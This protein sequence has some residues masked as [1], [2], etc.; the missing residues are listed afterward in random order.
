MKPSDF[1][2]VLEN[3][4]LES[5]S[6][7]PGDTLGVIY[8]FRNMGTAYADKDY[9]VFV[10]FERT[11]SCEKIPFQ[12]DHEPVISAKS[13]ASGKLIVDGPHQ[14]A[15]P[16]DAEE[17]EYFIHVGLFIPGGGGPHGERVYETYWSGKLTVSQDAPPPSPQPPLP[18]QEI[19][20]RIKRLR[21]RLIDSVSLENEFIRFNISREDG[22][23]EIL[24]KNSG[25]IWASSVT[26]GAFA[27]ITLVKGE[28]QRI[29]SV[30]RFKIFTTEPGSL[31]MLY[32]PPPE[33][34]DLTGL[35]V[36]F[37]ATLVA[38]APAIEFTW[39][40]MP[41]GDWKVQLVRF[42]DEALWVTDA[43]EGAFY[44]PSWLGVA[45]PANSGRMFSRRYPTYAWGGCQ[46]AMVGMSKKGAGL[47]VSWSDPYVTATVQ[48]TIQDLSILPGRQML[49]LTLEHGSASKNVR[50]DVV[51]GG[52]YVEICHAYRPIARAHGFLKL[53]PEKIRENPSAQKLIGAPIFKP[54]TLS[55]TIPGSRFYHGKGEEHVSIGYTFEET[56][57]IAEHLRY[58][59]GIERGLFV[60]AGWIHRGYDNQHPDILPA[61][62]ECGG[63]AALRKASER[64]RATGYLFG[65]HD[66]YLDFYRDAPSW[67]EKY[68][69]VNKDGSLRKGGNWA[70]GQAWFICP[71]MALELAKR[72][73]KNMP[74]VKELFAPTAYFT[75]TT[76]AVGMTECFSPTHPLDYHG[77]I[78]CRQALADYARSLFGVHGSE[79]GMEWAVP[80][81]HYFEGILSRRALGERM[82]PGAY[83]VPLFEL[84]YR[85]CIALYTHQGDKAGPD[86][87]DYILYHIGLGRMPLYAFG[88]HLYFKEEDKK[89][90]VRMLVLPGVEKVMPKTARQF[91]IT[92]RWSV[93][94]P[95]FVDVKR[96]FVHFTD[97]DGNIKFQDDHELPVS[98]GKW[99]KG[100]VILV[101]PRTVNVPEKLTGIFDIRVGLLSNSE[102][103]TLAGQ[104]DRERRYKVGVL[105]L[106][107]RGI[108]FRP[109]VQEPRLLDT[110]CFARCDGGWSEAQTP[111]LCRTDVFI[112]NTYEVLS[113]LNELTAMLP[114]TS[115]R[116]LTPDRLVEETVFGNNEVRVVI[117]GSAHD[118]VIDG[119][120]LPPYGFIVKSPTF[121]AFHAKTWNGVKYP[122]SA[123]FTI[124]SL[125]NRALNEAIRLRIFHAF[126]EPRIRFANLH[127]RAYTDSGQKITSTDGMFEM[128][129]PAEVRLEF[130]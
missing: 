8:Y 45:I 109:F 82:P 29:L 44:V 79:M 77:D 107:S 57:Q 90:P 104:P 18:A 25:E 101:G 60:L 61:A 32:V 94:A 13:W 9:R 10:H 96:V 64:I 14:I 86:S 54:F 12:Q 117:N 110:A 21:A 46:M 52:N 15:I 19:I 56:A 4:V 34:S 122:K 30:S 35:A 80:H 17:G 74:K 72:P 76:F 103:L 58:E 42:P 111:R 112:R 27:R 99:K 62:P 83:Q 127:R 78:Q 121:T 100:D 67:D 38:D 50:V 97:A 120:S 119:E 16:P 22:C 92:Y 5:N 63:D 36:R 43:Q 73:D 47:L 66:N 106:T 89:Q 55:R 118:V 3:V 40:V 2:P 128:T 11:Q 24:D 98:T 48:S 49:A 6:A 41:P 85:D 95:P 26:E 37:T 70:G 68:I 126:G 87:A 39:D 114:M 33:E 23:Y 115:H 125:D 124:R 88:P 84:V 7:R 108:S 20:E 102:R 59:V 129:V 1:K 81:S 93:N 113:P 28:Q 31:R 69:V 51:P 65:L 130:R 105:V 123:M 91:E 116:F 71:K 53:W 75:D